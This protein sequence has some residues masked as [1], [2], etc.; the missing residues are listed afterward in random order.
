VKKVLA[1]DD[2]PYVARLL[3]KVLKDAWGEDVELDWASDGGIGR[4]KAASGEYD[5]ITLDIAMP[6]MGGLEALEEIR[7]NPKSAHTPVV[8]ITGLED[9][10][11]AADAHSLGADAFVRKPFSAQELGRIIY[12]IAM[13]GTPPGPATT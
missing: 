9:P 10:H 8:V 3:R 1:I 5:L 12:E 4:L 2:E 11:L 7:R 13:R 6:M